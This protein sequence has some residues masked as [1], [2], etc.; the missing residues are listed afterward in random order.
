MSRDARQVSPSSANQGPSSSSASG[1][2]ALDSNQL[3]TYPAEDPPSPSPPP[4]MPAQ[5]QLLKDRLYVGNLH[6]TVDE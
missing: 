3:I 4:Q 2:K 5:P 1:S 6:P